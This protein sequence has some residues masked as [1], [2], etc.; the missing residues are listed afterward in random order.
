MIMNR[1]ALSPWLSVL[2]AASYCRSSRTEFDKIPPPPG[3]QLKPT[4]YPETSDRNVGCL[5][6]VHVVPDR[7]CPVRR[8]TRVAWTV[9]FKAIVGSPS[10]ETSIITQT[11]KS[12]SVAALLQVSFVLSAAGRRARVL[13]KALDAWIAR[14]RAAREAISAL[15]AM[16][17][18]ELRDI[19][20]GRSDIDRIAWR[21]PAD[22]RDIRHID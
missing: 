20:L 13:A 10:K 21:R 5:N 8:I 4:G 3:F 22:A 17:E 11:Q 6:C 15:N 19:G 2:L 1:I 7:N 9:F 18:R 12:I 16:S 14:R